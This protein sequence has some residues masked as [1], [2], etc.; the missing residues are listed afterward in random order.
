MRAAPFLYFPRP[1]D[2]RRAL[3]TART[4]PLEAFGAEPH[5][6]LSGIAIALAGVLEDGSRPHEAYEL[7][8]KTLDGLRTTQGLS[9][10][11]RVR[12]VALAHKLGEM[13]ETYQLPA[14]EEERWLV[15][16]VEELLR[17]LSD[18]QSAARLRAGAADPVK[19]HQLVLS[20]L[21][22]PPWVDLTDVVAPLQ[23]L[24]AFYNR[25]GKQ[26]CVDCLLLPR[27]RLQPSLTQWNSTPLYRY[28]VPLYL[29]AL[30][31]LMPPGSKQTS[32]ENRCRGAQLFS[33]A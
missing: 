30:N 5:L 10:K 8:A 18:E 31:F 23:S 29:S 16:A 14:A 19:E 20:E 28:A 4:L 33:R 2:A 15:Y 6:K 7:Y 22:L 32:A 21:E 11:E 12:T 24:G 13:A 1:T 9:G 17:V 26:E 27:S 25:A 3:E